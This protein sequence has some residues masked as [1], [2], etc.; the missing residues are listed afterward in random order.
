MVEPLANVLKLEL[1]P[2]AIALLHGA[3]KQGFAALALLNLQLALSQR[4]DLVEQR[5]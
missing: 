2:S 4:L 5:G 1:M 3:A